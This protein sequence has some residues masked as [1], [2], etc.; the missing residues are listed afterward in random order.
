MKYDDAIR[1]DVD[2]DDDGD[3]DGDV[4]GDDDDKGNY[5]D[6][7]LDDAIIIIILIITVVLVLLVAV[8]AAG[9]MV[10]VVVI[11][12][13]LI[14]MKTTGDHYECDD[15]DNDYATTIS[16][17]GQ[18]GVILSVLDGAGAGER[19]HEQDVRPEDPEE[20]PHRGDT[21]AG[22]HHEREENHDRGSLRLHR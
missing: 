13:I 22:T 8:V 2:D 5:E 9:V 7:D 11:M 6:H 21:P 15:G 17:A 10:V 12:T 4:D 16:L 14:M 18:P 1:R 20:T 3:G 19:R